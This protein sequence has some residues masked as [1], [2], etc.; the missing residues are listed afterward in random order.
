MSEKGVS[1]NIGLGQLLTH[2]LEVCSPA[3]GDKRTYI[4]IGLVANSVKI[5]SGDQKMILSNPNDKGLSRKLFEDVW[6]LNWTELITLCQMF[7]YI[8]ILSILVNPD[9]PQLTNNFISFWSIFFPNLH[10]FLPNARGVGYVEAFQFL[11]VRVCVY[12]ER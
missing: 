12:L 5:T 1:L 9:R 6:Q 10:I 3:G 8:I 11:S 7:K 2:E 4:W